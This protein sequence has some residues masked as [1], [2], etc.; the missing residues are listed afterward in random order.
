LPLLVVGLNKLGIFSV[1]MMNKWRKYIILVLAIVAAV[2]TSDP[3]S[4]M[5]L[6]IPLYLLFEISVLFCW[7]TQKKGSGNRG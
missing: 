2:L 5:A 3:L 6:G 1:T 7:L 4:L